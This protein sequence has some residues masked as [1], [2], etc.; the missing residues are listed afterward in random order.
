MELTLVL[1]TRTSLPT[2][3]ATSTRWIALWVSLTLDKSP[4]AFSH[5]ILVAWLREEIVWDLCRLHF[6][7]ICVGLK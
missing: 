3:T 5:L 6:G 1:L 2:V 7:G 4:R